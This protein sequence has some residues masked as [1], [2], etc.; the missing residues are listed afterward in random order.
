MQYENKT[1]QTKSNNLAKTEKQDC[2]NTERIKLKTSETNK[3]EEHN[4]N[5]RKKETRKR[6]HFVY[7]KWRRGGY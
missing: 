7:S 2:K 5:R 3:G 1:D 6:P 4:H